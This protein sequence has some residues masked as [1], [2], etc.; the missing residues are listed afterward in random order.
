MNIGQ[1]FAKSINRE[2]KPVV[3]PGQV[4]DATVKLE[5]QE[6]VVTQELQKHFA[7]FFSNYH[8]GIGADTDRIGVW[9]SGFF[10]SGKSH[11]LKMLSYL[12]SDKEVA[13]KP[14]LE[15][16][17]ED[18]KITDPKVL[19]DIRAAES[20]STDVILFDIA[21]K[22]RTSSA[23]AR[24]VITMVFLRAFNE[25]LGYSY[26]YPRMADLERKLDSEGKLQNFRGRVE[27]LEGSS[28]DDA[29]A[30]IDL[31]QDSFVQ[32]LVEQ[33]VMSEE[34]AR[35]WCDR[36]GEEYS[37]STEDFAKLV[38]K[39]IE[40]K[41]NDHHVV[42]CVDEV[43]QYIG[44]D[45]N[46]MLDLQTLEHDLAVQCHGKAWIL[47][48]AQEAID[49]IQVV[50]NVDFSKIQGRFDTRLSLSSSDVAEVVK[51]RILKKNA[52]A[53][54]ELETFYPRKSDALDTLLKFSGD[55]PEMK[56]YENA[57]D[58]AEVYPFVPYQ[59][60]LL[61]KVLDAVR[62]FSSPGKNSSYGERSMLS[63]YLSTAK[64]LQD[65]EEGILVPFNAFYQGLSALVD[66]ETAIAITNAQRNNSLNPDHA[67]TC[68]EVEVLK[69]LFMIK[70]VRE[71]D[72]PTVQNI[73]TLMA[74]RMNE[75]RY[76]L[77]NRLETA[78]KK[79]VQEQLVQNLGDNYVFL[80]NEEQEV[81]REIASR[82]P[83]DSEMNRELAT[84][85][86]DENYRADKY[87]YPYL[88]G[89]YS[90]GFNRKIDGYDAL[91]RPDNSI[92]VK[93]ITS[94]GDDADEARLK[95]LSSGESGDHTIFVQ[96]HDDTR[97]N[98]E[99]RMMLQIQNYLR[100]GTA[101]RI[102]K[103]RAICEAKQE[104]VEERRQNVKVFLK[105]A[106][107]EADIYVYGSKL[108]GGSR[109]FETRLNDALKQQVERL[110][111]H[112]TDIDKSVSEQDI[113]KLFADAGQMRLGGDGTGNS[114]ALDDVRT[115]IE[116][117]SLSRTVTTSLKTLLGIFTKE[118]Y[119]F[120]PVDVEWLVA[121]L[122]A[123]GILTLTMN[124]E[125]LSLSSRNAQEFQRLFTRV[126]SQE[127]L[128]CDIRKHATDKQKRLV[129]DMMRDLFEKGVSSDDDEQL[130]ADLK[131]ECTDLREELRRQQATYREEPYLPGKRTVNVGIALM[132]SL[133]DPTTTESFYTALE[134]AQE[135]YQDFKETYESL[136]DFFNAGQ[137]KVFRE[138]HDAV[139]LYMRNQSRIDDGE[140]KNAAEGM[141]KILS[142]AEPYDKIRNLAVLH[143]TFQE[144][145]REL[146]DRK[147]EPVKDY[148]AD[149][150]G[151]VLQHLN[152]LRCKEHYWSSVIAERDDALEKIC[153]TNNL[154]DLELAKLDANRTK[155]N[156][157]NTIDQYEAAHQPVV[158]TPAAKVS[159]GVPAKA[160]PAAPVRRRVTVSIQEVTDESWQIN[161][162]AELDAYI[163]KLRHALKQKLDNGDTLNVD[164]W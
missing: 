54:A 105:Q 84:L 97:L 164:I 126:E 94:R 78:L 4:D 58:F 117:N 115:R 34:S 47:V 16:F 134:N 144:K 38:R 20:V 57:A 86:F 61:G 91:S 80:T 36:V 130:M 147:S 109:D 129:R 70:N 41:G 76:Q 40:S 83:E 155:I 79:L 46:M 128:L 141:R 116:R 10:G 12:I 71:F 127:R 39:H 74:S 50:N 95:M 158:Q 121:R 1:M 22:S 48:T 96:L 142:M 37:I 107:S 136:R 143:T 49:K 111:N 92:T 52:E 148:V 133:I 66:H 51:K 11:F 72:K 110:F 68:F 5:L 132:T 24:D 157:I 160:A 18:D 29:V 108:S 159:G 161:N 140:V 150:Y 81:N 43:G 27:E 82:R 19:A 14:A 154:G 21:S 45:S 33:G 106:L 7:A 63:M 90:F 156:W 100:S 114:R 64:S 69:V 67:E 6:Y 3:K 135:D 112:L 93:I 53:Q 123:D 35:S 77:E 56:L 102:T 118:P 163:E 75:D 65:Q 153:S 120:L 138:A 145:Y 59:F 28:W 25:K 9:I 137:I 23:A 124:H 42:F 32:A 73:A 17:I 98:N 26:Q 15:Y 151:R 88:N 122:F 31:A 152:T 113:G 99:L 87:R 13:G 30:G 55:M 146:L 149:C 44:D 62:L 85:I 60:N 131:K 101:G 104:E 89:R 103:Y 139:E 125:Q 8:R 162:A 2:I 119:G